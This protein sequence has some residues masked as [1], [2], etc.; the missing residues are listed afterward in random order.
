MECRELRDNVRLV[1]TA[2]ELPRAATDLREDLS[3]TFEALQHNSEAAG[4]L[5]T[6]LQTEITE[7]QRAFTKLED[8]L[9]ELDAQRSLLDLTP[10]QRTGLKVFLK[11][12]PTVREIWTSREFLYGRLLLSAFSFGLGV[13]VNRYW[14]PGR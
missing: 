5:I 6:R 7:R 9:R 1:I 3:R 13:I 12:Q 2:A 11:R 14:L 10:E 8:E 4:R